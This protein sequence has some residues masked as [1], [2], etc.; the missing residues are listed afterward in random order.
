MFFIVPSWFDLSLFKGL[1]EAHVL[2]W[3]NGSNIK[4]RALENVNQVEQVTNRI[5]FIEH[6]NHHITT[7]LI[8]KAVGT[9]SKF[10]TKGVVECLTH[11]SHFY[12]LENEELYGI[13]QPE[14]INYYVDMNTKDFKRQRECA[15]REIPNLLV[16][17]LIMEIR[18]FE[19]IAKLQPNKTKPKYLASCLYLAFLKSNNDEK[20]YATLGLFVFGE[21]ARGYIRK[22]YDDNLIPDEYTAGIFNIKFYNNGTDLFEGLPIPVIEHSL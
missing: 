9:Q 16:D 21:H 18:D 10:F 2:I 12:L 1:N 11:P 19:H 4:V 20:E 3:K 15:Q 5:Y 7:G 6:L 8:H 14:H 17:H 22:I 13:K